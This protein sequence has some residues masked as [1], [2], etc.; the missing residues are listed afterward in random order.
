MMMKRIAAVGAALLIAGS[1]FGYVDQ[2]PE[3][4]NAF[5][6]SA[7]VRLA[8]TSAATAAIT[9]KLELDLVGVCDTSLSTIPARYDDALRIDTTMSP[10][11]EKIAS[12]NLD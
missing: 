2:H 3:A 11:S 7:D 5:N 9:D 6:T 12:L 4:E 1:L 10:D 8:A